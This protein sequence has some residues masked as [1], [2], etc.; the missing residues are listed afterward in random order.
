MNFKLN[1]MKKI[2]VMISV[3]AMII[4]MTS[5]E[6]SDEVY[7]SFLGDWHLVR[8]N[9]DG[10]YRTPKPNA[11]K[12]FNLH[13]MKNNSLIGESVSSSFSAVYNI[14]KRNKI[15]WS[16]FTYLPANQDDTDNNAFINNMLKINKYEMEG[17]TLKLLYDKKTYLLFVRK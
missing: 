9:V 12:Y 7:N 6:A 13:F 1:V 10:E 11:E 5:C 14:K 17:D 3:V 8:I 16:G 2:L 15:V 4:A